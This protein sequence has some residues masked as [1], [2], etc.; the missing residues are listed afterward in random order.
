MAGSSLNP[1]LI[2]LTLAATGCGGHRDD[3]NR[4]SVTVRLPP[5]RAATPRPGFSLE[6]TARAAQ[7]TD[8][9]AS[10]AVRD[11]ANELR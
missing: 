11:L 2:A 3:D 9:A 10:D 8:E 1:F 4:G 7:P 5:A 6:S